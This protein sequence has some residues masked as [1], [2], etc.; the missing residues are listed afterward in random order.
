MAFDS[1]HDFWT[2]NGH[3]PYVWT[4]YGVFFLGM[5]ALVVGSLIQRRRVIER[6]RWQLKMARRQASAVT[7][8]TNEG[9]S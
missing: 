3:G 4:C 9:I 2:M 1:L 5:A 8:R 7:P 6:Q